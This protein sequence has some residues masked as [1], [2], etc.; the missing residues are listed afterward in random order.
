MKNDLCDM[1]TFMRKLNEN[2]VLL[3]KFLCDGYNKMPPTEV[4][5]L[6]TEVILL[7]NENPSNSFIEIK[8]ELKDIKLILNKNPTVHVLQPVLWQQQDI[9]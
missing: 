3:L 8:E 5:L 7:K 4:N 9:N 6:W 2:E 1:L